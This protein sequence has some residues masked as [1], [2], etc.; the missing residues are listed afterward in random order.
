MDGGG[1]GARAAAGHR[2]RRI[3]RRGITGDGQSGVPVAV[4]DSGLALELV[5]GTRSPLGLRAGLDRGSGG[6]REGAGGCA[7]RSIAGVRSRGCWGVLQAKGASVKVRRGLAG[8][9][10]GRDTA[11]V[12]VQNYRRRG[13]AVAR[14]DTR[15]QV[16]AERH[17]PPGSHGESRC[18]SANAGGGSIGPEER[19]R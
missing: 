5:R 16:A 13:P 18:R 10:R 9:H 11:G 4:L 14:C 8:A 2:R 12:A 1:L 3:P 19:R 17:R 15:G 6:V 7:R